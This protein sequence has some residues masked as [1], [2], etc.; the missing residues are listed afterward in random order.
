MIEGFSTTVRTWFGQG[1]RVEREVEQ[2][3]CHR[4]GGVAEPPVD[5]PLPHCRHLVEQYGS[6]EPVGDHARVEEE[7]S[8][9]V[10]TGWLGLTGDFGDRR[11]EAR[12][13]DGVKVEEVRVTRVVMGQLRETDRRPARHRA[14][15]R[16]P[17]AGAR[18]PAARKPVL[19]QANSLKSARDH[20]ETHRLPGKMRPGA[21]P[22]PAPHRPPGIEANG[23]AAAGEQ[24]GK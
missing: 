7:G 4:S 13:G 15:S 12:A 3:Q 19:V 24:D 1:R 9:Q 20:R 22:G 10:W 17:R 16:R 11:D 5:R 18:D 21:G 23:E 14:R 6:C 2:G 8:G